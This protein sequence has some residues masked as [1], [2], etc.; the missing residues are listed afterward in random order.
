MVAV[1]LVP[2]GPA[3]E[4]GSYWTIY[5]FALAVAYSVSFG[6]AI[7]EL[8]AGEHDKSATE[9]GLG[10]VDMSKI[11]FF[12]IVPKLGFWATAA[13][14]AETAADGGADVL[15]GGSV[16]AAELA[17]AGSAAVVFFT[18]AYAEWLQT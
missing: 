3:A 16:P 18:A 2:F 7:G 14:Y 9:I 4:A 1:G 8:Y 15:S 5:A 17:L 10:V 13:F 12:D 6:K 11:I